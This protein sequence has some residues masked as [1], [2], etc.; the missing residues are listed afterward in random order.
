M[1]PHKSPQIHHSLPPTLTPA[2]EESC[3]LWGNL[4]LSLKCRGRSWYQSQ[5]FKANRLTLIFAIWFS[6]RSSRSGKDCF[7]FT[8]Q[9]VHKT[10]WMY[11]HWEESN[12]ASECCYAAM[13][14]DSQVPH[15][16]WYAKWNG[17]HPE[18][19]E[20]MH[21]Y[22]C[23][24]AFQLQQHVLSGSSSLWLCCHCFPP[25]PFLFCSIWNLL[26]LWWNFN[27]CPVY[28]PWMSSNRT[29][30]ACYLEYWW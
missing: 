15:L 29:T 7:C 18:S 4:I 11:S 25:S 5:P 10:L 3:L 22:I 17:I 6:G 9:K 26:F 13:P 14:R 1:C 20:C 8:L 19:G 24:T 21:F 30:D 12:S 16:L 28:V 27:N 23:S 2:S